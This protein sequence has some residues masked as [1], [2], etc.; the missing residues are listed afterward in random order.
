L[1]EDQE[2]VQ[3]VLRQIDM[4]LI[5]EKQAILMGLKAVSGMLQNNDVS[6][7]QQLLGSSNDFEMLKK[8]LGQDGQQQ[9]NPTV[10]SKLS[11]L[12]KL[13]PL[14]GATVGAA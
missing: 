14:A 8:W 7:L 5:A 11:I 4:G 13:T 2:I 3:H 6:Q 10:L 1:K 9:D 12:T